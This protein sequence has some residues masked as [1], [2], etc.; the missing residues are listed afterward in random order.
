[1]DRGHGSS[2][3]CELVL[4]QFAQVQ[5]AALT[6]PHRGGH[7]RPDRTRRKPQPL[8]REPSSKRDQYVEAAIAKLADRLDQLDQKVSAAS[9]N[10]DKSS[11]RADRRLHYHDGTPLDF[12]GFDTRHRLYFRTSE[13]TSISRLIINSFPKLTDRERISVRIAAPAHQTLLRFGQRRTAYG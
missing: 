3:P 13:R 11:N 1:M 4:Q 5:Q 6:A 12:H 9:I 2:V 10:G 8:D 7:A